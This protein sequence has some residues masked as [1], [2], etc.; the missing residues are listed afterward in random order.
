MKDNRV[1]LYNCGYNPVEF[2]GYKKQAD[3]Q[4]IVASLRRQLDRL[5]PLEQAKKSGPFTAAT[6]VL[7]SMAQASQA[8]L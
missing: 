8:N 3:G 1:H 5:I 4:R 6:T 2:D 7:A